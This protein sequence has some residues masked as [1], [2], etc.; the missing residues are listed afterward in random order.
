MDMR[1]VAVYVGLVAVGIAAGAGTGFFAASTSGG[2]AAGQN[3]VSALEAQSEQDLE[4]LNVKRKQG[5][6][7]V[8][9]RTQND[10]VQTYY[11][12]PDGNL[13]F[14]EGSATNTETLTRVVNQREKLGNCLQRKQVRLYG[15]IS[16][17]ATQ[18]QI[19]ALGQANLDGVYSD[20]NNAS[21]LRTAVQQG[22]NRTP[23]F[24]HDGSSLSGINTP[25]QVAEF[26][27]CAYNV[28]Q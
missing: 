4:L 5:M 10:R 20:V 2:Q 27:G 9:V 15:N 7:Q 22:V 28:T 13:F 3:I 8:D 14:S 17:R 1:T 16:Q 25:S 26:T 11:A 24:M 6:F 19:Q 21:V 23:A 18:V 12:S